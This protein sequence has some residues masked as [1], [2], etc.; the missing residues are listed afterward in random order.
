MIGTTKHDMAYMSAISSQMGPAAY[1]PDI[2]VIKHTY[3]R[4]KFGQNPRFQSLTKQ[5]LNKELNTINFCTASPGPK[6]LSK[7]S[8]TD[9][10]T[11][12]PAAYSFGSKGDNVSDRGSFLTSTIKGGFLYRAK[13]AT[14]CTVNG[15]GPS[16]YTPNIATIN[17]TA[18]RPQWGKAD[19]FKPVAKIYVSSKH[20]RSKVGQN[21]PGPCY[22]PTNS[23][24]GKVKIG[25]SVAGKWCP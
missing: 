3:P 5:Y 6:Y 12:K 21:S 13:P 2:R 23:N 11:R 20:S 4:N 7:V 16:N 19:R 15:V 8:N 22:F 1:S 10:D 25:V 17:Q 9:L 24:L 18:P 14:S